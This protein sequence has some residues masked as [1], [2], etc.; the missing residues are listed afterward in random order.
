M[1][2]NLINI[3]N[4]G[5]TI[6]QKPI[7]TPI[8]FSILPE[9][10]LTFIGPNGAGKSTLLRMLSFISFADTGRIE[11]LIPGFEEVSLDFSSSKKISIDQPELLTIRKN[12]LYLFQKP[13]VFSSSVRNNLILSGK[14]RGQKFSDKECEIV[15][16][17]VGLSKNIHQ[18]ATTLSG[19]EMSRLAFARALLLKPKVLFLD[20]PSAH[21]DPMGVKSVEEWILELKTEY[22]TTIFLVTQDLFEAKRVSDRVGF[23]LSGQ[24]IELNSKREF[25]EFPKDPK[26]K[27]FVTGELP[28]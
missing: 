22:K 14:L 25:F 10:V 20:E 11:Y 27:L 4:L 17:K 16:H 9:E 21:L 23:L 8:C 15:L 19:G 18:N 13:A 3:I 5:L 26:T 7:V 2:D 28:I 1:P 6:D 24:L 12:M